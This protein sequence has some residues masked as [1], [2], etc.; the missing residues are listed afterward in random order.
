M[1]EQ[2]Q[3]YLRSVLIQC[4]KH[5]V[6]ILLKTGIELY[7]QTP[8]GCLNL[9]HEITLIY[10]YVGNYC[11][12]GITSGKFMSIDNNV[13]DMQF[14]SNITAVTCNPGLHSRRQNMYNCAQQ[15]KIDQGPASRNPEISQFQQSIVKF[16]HKVILNRP[17]VVCPGR[18]RVFSDS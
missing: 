14:K 12:D 18:S 11:Y 2:Y 7:L 15:L 6:G 5:F 8:V 9:T 13:C 1:F 16:L 3:K 10:Y 17:T 4:F